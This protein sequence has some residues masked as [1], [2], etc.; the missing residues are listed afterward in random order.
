MIATF[1]WNTDPEIINLFGTFP[2]KYYGIFFASGLLLGFQVVKQIY[3]KKGIATENL[4]SLSLY[5]LFGTIIGARLGHCL[6]Y[7]PAYFLAHPIE[8]FV[9][10]QQI[11]GAWQ[12]TGFNGLASHGGALG[13]LLAIFWYT[14]KTGEKYLS[15]LDNIA[16]ATPLVA[17]FIR[18]GNFMNSEIIGKPT[19]SDYGVIFQRIDNLPRHPAQL[20]EA[21]SYLLIFIILFLVYKRDRPRQY[22][23]IFGLFIVLVFSIRFILE[24]FKTNQASFESGMILNMGQMLSIPF[25][26][27]GLFLLISQKKTI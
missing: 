23:F 20:Y 26:L 27:I 18:L 5:I 16:I 7:E 3:I 9:P 22:G 14:R 15:V 2:L 17:T 19:N 8:I 12:Y 10:M 21:L 6:F 4:D 24:F 25:V 13:V 11:N 1:I